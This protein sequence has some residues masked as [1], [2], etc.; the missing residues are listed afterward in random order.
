M[1]MMPTPTPQNSARRRIPAVFFTYDQDQE[2]A[3]FTLRSYLALWPGL[4]L[5]F[6]IPYTSQAALEAYQSQLPSD[7]PCTF[8]RTESA[9]AAALS[10]LIGA[11]LLKSDSPW[12]FWCT[13]DRIP[14]TFADPPRLCGLASL[15]LENQLPHTSDVVRL[16][17]WRDSVF[18]S[19]AGGAESISGFPFTVNSL[20][21]LF[22]FWHPQ[23]VSRRFL[24]WI[25]D[26]ASSGQ[27]ATMANLNEKLL[28]SFDAMAFRGLLP[29]QTLAK[30]VEPTHHGKWTLNYRVDRFRAGLSVGQAAKSTREF[31]TFSNPN[32]KNVN[33]FWEKKEVLA[34]ESLGSLEAPED[35]SAFQNLIQRKFPPLPTIVAT[36]GGSGSK[37]L[38]RNIYPHE[39]FAVLKQA[40]SHWRVPPVPLQPGQKVVYLYGDPRNTVCSF[41]ARRGGI[42]HLH[43]FHTPSKEQQQ[44]VRS[45]WVC[46]ALKNL[47]TDAGPITADWDLEKFLCHGVEQFRLEEHFDCWM[48]AGLPYPVYFCRYETLWENWGR[49]Q[50]ALGITRDDLP[51]KENRRSSWADLPEPQNAA[52]HKMLGDFALRLETLPDLFKAEN[53]TLTDLK[54]DSVF[55]PQIV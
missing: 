2:T 32:Q 33:R 30:F 38:V 28:E 47:E 46:Q 29:R 3:L 21:T 5:D 17:R 43:D 34:P 42:T 48:Y 20:S 53:G 44:Q 25:G 14:I 54:T 26:V 12:F 37:F 9:I 4:P 31:I 36:Y 24:T 23:F 55:V 16:T 13:S 6:V 45:G 18:T 49:L 15:L 11:V 41:F 8:V 50:H 51:A 40:H 39:E 10:Q 52:L 27:V 7:L 35:D 1:N 22:G 19:P